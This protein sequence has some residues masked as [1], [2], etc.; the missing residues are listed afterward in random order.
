[1]SHSPKSPEKK[2]KEHAKAP[3]PPTLQ[4]L[5]SYAGLLHDYLPNADQVFDKLVLTTAEGPA[6]TIE[7]PPH[8]GQEL[9]AAAPVGTAVTVLGFARPGPKAALHLAS[10][11]LGTRTLRPLPPP[12]PAPPTAADAVSLTGTV[13]AQQVDP[14][15][16]LRGVALHDGTRLAFRP[17][18]GA[19]L[20][21]RLAVGTTLAV[22]GLRQPLRPGEAA[23]GDQRPVR[24]EL[25]TLGDEHFLVR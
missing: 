18:L 12:P 11:A 15:G 21:G 8:F 25:L 2:P 7:F 4:P 14:A 17:H 1:M 20:A 9:R 10:L 3:K 16:H 22:S 5:T 23:A 19:E 24:V 13:A 6:L